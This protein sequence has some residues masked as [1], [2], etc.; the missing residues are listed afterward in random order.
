MLHRI[1]R[2][3]ILRLLRLFYPRVEVQGREYL[4][5]DGPIIFVLNHPNGLLDPLLLMASLRRQIA[6]LAKSTF[7]GNPLGRLCMDAFGALPVYR[8]HDQPDARSA[9]LNERNETTF[10][11]CRALLRRHIALALFP[12]GTTH[13]GAELLP[14]K[15]GAARIALS[16][17]DEAGWQLGLRIVPVGLWYQNK[18]LFRSSALLVVGPPFTIAEYRAQYAAQ[19]RA[20]VQSLTAAIA[21]ALEG[22]VLEA[23]N[24]ELLTGMPVIA[25]WTAPGGP[26]ATLPQQ[27]DRAAA[28][29][30]AYERLAAADPELALRL[31]QQ[32]RRYARTLRTLGIRDPWALEL[33]TVRGWHLAGLALWL[34]LALPLALAGFALSYGPY[35]L[36]GLIT[37]RLVGYHDTLLGTGKLI[38]GSA[39]VLIGWLIAATLAGLLFGPWRGL[40]VFALAPLL[41]YSALRW[42][43][44]WRSFREALG[45]SWFR[46]RH[47]TLRQHLIERRLALTQQVLAATELVEALPAP[48]PEAASQPA[49]IAPRLAGS[50]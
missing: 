44:S 23:E 45:Y 50:R 27:R 43:E 15:T 39:L 20:A 48:E 6:F 18:T 21:Q 35:R 1:V 4:P 17:E 33:A 31:A 10:A 34:L 24:A 16:A 42:G 38:A 2:F 14:L 19:P 32:A 3:A 8:Q 47:Q 46:V 49:S 11:R 36:A 26:P 37:P 22:V 40:G 29:L 12:E 25:A 7:F 41:G 9:A 13:S 28:L 5:Q 30:A